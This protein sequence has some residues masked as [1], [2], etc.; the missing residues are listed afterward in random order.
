MEEESN[1]A[2]EES[3][4]PVR[5]DPPLALPFPPDRIVSPDARLSDL[6]FCSPLCLPTRPDREGFLILDIAFRA[7]IAARSTSES[8]AVGVERSIT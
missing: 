4:F 2:E 6:G 3:D 8:G 1:E 7:W 5:A